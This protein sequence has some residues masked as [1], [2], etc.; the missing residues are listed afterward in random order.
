MAK[1]GGHIAGAGQLL[2]AAAGLVAGSVAEGAVNAVSSTLA[3]YIRT[4]TNTEA[5]QR[6]VADALRDQDKCFLFVVDDLD[7]LTP[8]EALVV[9]RL[10]KS[11]D[12][13][14][15]VAYLLSYDREV[16]EKVVANR[17]PSEGAHYLEKIVQAGFDLPEPAPMHL[18]KLFLEQIEPLFLKDDG[19]SWLDSDDTHLMN[20]F[21]ESIYPE[22]RTPRDAVRL[23]NSLTITWGAV[24]GEVHPG[25]FAV[26]EALRLFRPA[27]YRAVRTSKHRLV[28]TS[29][30][31]RQT[32]DL[33]KELEERLIGSVLSQDRK[34]I[35]N[36]LMR[37]FPRLQA[38]WSNMH[39]SSEE[40]WTRARR[41][42][43]VRRSS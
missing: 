10:I 9:L 24:R 36:V 38:I 11:V 6:H 41:C 8:D 17:Y 14:P 21:F 33:A 5:L 26:L 13:L 1:L 42:P 23:A 4:D 29:G 39:Y 22:L 12:R 30:S 2:G 43:P 37:L 35:R 25:D 7:R 3:N 27:V 15:N 28:G 20:L 31:D 34:R 40:A 16:T 32:Q 18:Q 19:E